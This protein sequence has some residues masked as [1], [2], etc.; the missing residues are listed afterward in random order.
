VSSAAAGHPTKD[1]AIPTPKEFDMPGSPRYRFFVLAGSLVLLASAA[2]RAQDAAGELT[3]HVDQPGPTVGPMFYGLMTEE[4]NHSY[5]G[6]LYAELIQN[7]IFKDR[8][9]GRGARTDPAS[10]PHWS[11]VKV[12]DADGSITLDDANPV[13]TTA[14]TT[15]LRLDAKGGGGRIG[16]ANDGYWGIPVKPNT[17]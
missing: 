4:I 2:A 3:V 6:G 16:V 8:A 14:L 5:D 11:I 12:D 17:Q 9:G 1:R 13:N 7:R 10:P 15:S